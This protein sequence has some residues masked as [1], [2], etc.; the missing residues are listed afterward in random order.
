MSKHVLANV[1]LVQDIA[2]VAASAAQKRDFLPS[3]M[4]LYQQ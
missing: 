4:P 2:V 3:I 1:S